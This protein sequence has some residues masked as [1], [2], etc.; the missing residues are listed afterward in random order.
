M[1]EGTGQRNM[2]AT[3]SIGIGVVSFNLDSSVVTSSFRGDR[4]LICA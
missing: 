4:W 2:P 3:Y 1:N